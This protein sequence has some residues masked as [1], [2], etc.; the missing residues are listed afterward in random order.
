MRRYISVDSIHMSVL[1]ILYW[2]TTSHALQLGRTPLHIAA[3]KGHTATVRILLAYAG[4]N[5]DAK[6]TVCAAS[7][8]YLM[9]ANCFVGGG[10]Q[11]VRLLHLA[12]SILSSS[13]SSPYLS[14]YF[15]H[16]PTAGW[17]YPSRLGGLPRSF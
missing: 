9:H 17:Q 12:S 10:S 1:T 11:Q 3:G 14:L 6:D 4:L 5:V 13:L 15:W 8:N 16:V 7:K 2:P